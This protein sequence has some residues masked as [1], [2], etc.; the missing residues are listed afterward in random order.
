MEGT[1]LYVIEVNNEKVVSVKVLLIN[2]AKVILI[3]AQV[4]K[5]SKWRRVG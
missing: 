1:K 3:K 5:V 2:Q 4:S